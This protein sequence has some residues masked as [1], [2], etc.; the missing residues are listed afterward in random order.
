MKGAQDLPAHVFAISY[1]SL[2]IKGKNTGIHKIMDW[3]VPSK[4]TTSNVTVF[5]T[6][7]L[8]NW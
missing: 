5:G 3:I 2:K 4:F 8:E 7:T 1:K 6:T